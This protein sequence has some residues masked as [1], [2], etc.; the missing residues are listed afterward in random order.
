MFVLNSMK[1]PN[2]KGI[3]DKRKH[4]F[5][6]MKLILFLLLFDLIWNLK[7][8]LIYEESLSSLKL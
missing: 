5:S 6:F 7:S 2:N 3:T 8:A 4:V 1:Y